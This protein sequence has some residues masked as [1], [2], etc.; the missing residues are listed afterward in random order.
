MF[1]YVEF[2]WWQMIQYNSWSDFF[3]NFRT[4]VFG[5][6]SDLLLSKYQFFLVAVKDLLELKTIN[7]NQLTKEEQVKH[8]EKEDSV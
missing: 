1:K 8:K 7:N 6:N 4:G 2:M 5:V 3:T